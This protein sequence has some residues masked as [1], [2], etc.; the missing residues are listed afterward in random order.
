L[1]KGLKSALRDNSSSE[2]EN[3]SSE[4]R[5]NWV[6][7]GRVL[8]RARTVLGLIV[9]NL[10]VTSRMELQVRARND[11]EREEGPQQKNEREKKE[12]QA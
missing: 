10:R 2:E 4:N 12:S 11:A 6:S 7:F 9:L 8:D 3:K 5:N 1:K